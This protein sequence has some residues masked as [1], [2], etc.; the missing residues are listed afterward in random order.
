LKIIK[1]T[2]I[3]KNNETKKGYREGERNEIDKRGRYE[4]DGRGRKGE[5][6]GKRYEINRR[7]REGE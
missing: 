5:R 6:E 7:G 2:A 4:I 3:S 1:T